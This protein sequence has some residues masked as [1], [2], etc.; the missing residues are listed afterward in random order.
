M[1]KTILPIIL[2]AFILAGCVVDTEHKTTR[3]ITDSI[4]RRVEVPLKV[5][6]IVP[7]GNTPRMITYLD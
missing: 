7:L 2:M 5:E 4:G 6:K 1:K 3:I